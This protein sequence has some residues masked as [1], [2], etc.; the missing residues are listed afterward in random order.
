M[1]VLGCTYTLEHL[2]SRGFKTFPELFD[3]SYGEIEGDYSRFMFIMD[4]I[5]RVCRLPDEVLHETYVSI[6]PKIKHNQQIFYNST[7][8]I[9]KE[10]DELEKE[11]VS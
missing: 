6:L 5:E 8:K 4:E 11:L 3:E 7:E 1:I 2:R 10:M 9:H